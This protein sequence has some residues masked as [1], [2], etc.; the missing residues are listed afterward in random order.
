MLEVNEHQ[1]EISVLSSE[2]S[3]LDSEAAPGSRP[4][5]IFVTAKVLRHR[6]AMA[7][8]E[9]RLEAAHAIER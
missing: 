9:S 8:L 7:L 6:I 3:R 5:V 1:R 4:R 2:L